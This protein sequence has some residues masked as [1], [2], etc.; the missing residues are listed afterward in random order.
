MTQA[1]RP[2]PA[3]PKSEPTDHKYITRTP[4]ICGGEPAINGT[5]IT[6][7]DVVSML[8]VGY[9]PD[10]LAGEAYPHITLAQVYDA[11]SFYHDHPDEIEDW[12]RRHNARPEHLSLNPAKP[13]GSPTV[14]ELAAAQAV[15][16][17]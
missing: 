12:I 16:K 1:T 14:R 8:R 5:R 3:P 11:L 9:T 4:G 7:R 17:R 13:A 6:V 10:T 15:A 2:A